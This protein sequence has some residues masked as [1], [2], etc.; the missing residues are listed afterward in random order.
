MEEFKMTIS[1]ING[2]VVRANLTER[3]IRLINQKLAE[4]NQILEKHNQMAILLDLNQLE[5]KHLEIV[6][7]E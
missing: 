2:G 1:E 6:D 5:G 7:D 3:E 4:I